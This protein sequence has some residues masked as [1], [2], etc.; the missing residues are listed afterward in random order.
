MNDRIKIAVEVDDDSLAID[1]INVPNTLRGGIAVGAA[2]L[3]ATLFEIGLD[4]HPLAT[5]LLDG[6][7]VAAEKAV[8]EMVGV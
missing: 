3:A 8:T 1:I 7:T 2:L 4:N 5:A 6:Y